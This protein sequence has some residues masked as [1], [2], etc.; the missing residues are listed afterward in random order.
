MTAADIHT[1]EALRRLR[2]EGKLSNPAGVDD[3][4]ASFLLETPPATDI[5]RGVV[6]VPPTRPVGA[7]Q[8]ADP[9]TEPLTDTL[10]QLEG[11]CK[12]FHKALD[13][14]TSMALDQ[15]KRSLLQLFEDTIRDRIVSSVM[16]KARVSTAFGAAGT[17]ANAARL[18]PFDAGLS[19]KERGMSD[20]VVEDS[21]RAEIAS[22]IGVIASHELK[23]IVGSI[24]EDIN[25]VMSSV[26]RIK[27]RATL[28]E[29]QVV[30]SNVESKMHSE[31]LLH[32]EERISSLQNQVK[33]LQDHH[34]AKDAQMDVLRE[35]LSR[36]NQSLDEAR[37]R[38]RKEVLRYKQRIFE[39]E[40]AD[41]DGKKR[42]VSGGSWEKDGDAAEELTAAAE[43]AVREA[44]ISV[45]E[46][47]HKRDIQFQRERKALS[48]EMQMKI[49]ERDSEIIRLKEKLRS[50]LSH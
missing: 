28:L 2:E 50:A 37:I 43:T 18:R 36:R 14:N 11:E 9:E 27:S 40:P 47:Q 10:A 17:G 4:S 45:Q 33:A 22:D 35:Q 16:K 46:E 7:K 48:Q 6:D 29:E 41:A 49:S 15:I 44:M 25:R 32:A 23:R 13:T 21:L 39:L 5:V 42:R 24:V 31:Q 26:Q 1:K 38:F 30:Q 3:E 20:F 8:T 19:K 12:D 34:V